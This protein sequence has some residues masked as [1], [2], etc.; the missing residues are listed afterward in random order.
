[1]TALPLDTAMAREA[2]ETPD[3]ARRQLDRTAGAFAALG[4]HLRDR[5]VPL[6]VTCARGSSDHAATYGKYLIETHLGIPVASVG[7]SV[8]SLYNTPLRLKGALFVA[9]SQSGRSPDL[10][11]L[12]EHARREGAITVAFV[13]DEASPLFQAVDFPIPLCAGPEL[14]VAATKSY[15]TSALAFLQLVA[16]WRDD[17][18]LRA[19]AAAAPDWLARACDLDWYPALRTLVSVRGLYVIARGIGSGA[20]MEMALKCKETS[21]LHAEAFS[22][23]EVIHGPLALVGPDFPVLAVTQAD[24][25]LEPTRAAITRMVSLGGPVLSTDASIPGTIALPSLAGQPPEL[26]PLTAVES[27]YLAIHRIARD[28]GL[29]PDVPPNLR[30]VTETI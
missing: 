22:A 12:T 5:D 18:D 17:A 23:A 6:V 30:K 8:V 24:A 4:R 25:T 7:P 26:A 9:V 21:R 3:A 15:L 19:T 28:R 27:F 10:L 16:A 20:A 14:S 11:R 29:D 1:M 2:A 13:N